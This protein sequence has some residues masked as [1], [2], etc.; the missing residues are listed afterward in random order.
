MIVALWFAISAMIVASMGVSFWAFLALCGVGAVC[1]TTAY[2]I[3]QK[4]L[5][6]IERLEKALV[7]QTV[8]RFTSRVCEILESGNDVKCKECEYLMFSDCYGE[9]RK[10]YKGI[11]SPN[12]SCGRGKRKGGKE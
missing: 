8:Q 5:K 10:G 11:V 2:F 9:C 1:Y 12:D 3:W 6:R 7:E 4:T